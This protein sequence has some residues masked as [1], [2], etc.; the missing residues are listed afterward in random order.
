M[1]LGLDI[2]LT[3]LRTRRR[4]TMIS[5]G[6]V[7][8]GVGFFIG[9]TAMMTG[10]HKEFIDTI[11]DVAPHIA[12]EDEF[13][14]PQPQPAKL[15]HP[16]AAVQLLSVKPKREPRG[17]RNGMGRL[18]RLERLPGVEVA[19]ALAGDVFLRYGA[20]EESVS[21]VGID[22]KRERK[23]S[24][25]ESDL[26]AGTLDDLQLTANGIILGV[27]IAR[28][29]GAVVDDTL[30]AISSKNVVMKVKVVG[31]FETGVTAFDENRAYMLLKKTQVLR[32]KINI[33]NRLI[34][35]VDDVHAAPEIAAKVE[36]LVGYKAVSWQ[37]ANQ[38]VFGLFVVQN[39]IMYTITSAILVVAAFGIYNIISTTVYEKT[40]DIAILKS[41]GLSEND[42]ARIFLWQGLL[43]AGIGTLAGWG[44][45]Y[46]LTRLLEVIPIQAQG[47]MKLESFIVVY[48]WQ[49]YAIAGGFAGVAA[50]LAAW[51][52]ARKAAKVRP[53]DIIRGAA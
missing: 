21:L 47:I 17:I 32:D 44:L 46:W 27:G 35:R 7:M 40:R 50:V 6:G 20:K 34:L 14:Y 30:T 37:E 8:L 41:M 9:T 38:G 1:P 3:H 29:L 25:L 24:D 23:V 26:I 36:R 4:Q 45:G 5:V 19:P 15:R 28:K 12:V 13:R 39:A 2:A 49:H 43:I 51:I 11:L 10:F 52:P 33:I 18:A 42:V 16:E 53:V 48:S 22:L 31:L